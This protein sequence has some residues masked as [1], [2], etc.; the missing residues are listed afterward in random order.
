MINIETTNDASQ[1]LF[2]WREVIALLYAGKELAIKQSE[3]FDPIFFHS[4]IAV[5]TG[6]KIVGC[7]AVFDNPNL[8]YQGLL[9]SAIGKFECAEDEAASHL[10]IQAAIKE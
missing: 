1:F 7:I 9:A 3:G 5:F 10:L 4:G 8:L 6:G 2:W